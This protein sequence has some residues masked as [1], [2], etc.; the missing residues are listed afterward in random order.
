MSHVIDYTE[1]PVG[2]G[3]NSRLYPFLSSVATDEQRLMLWVYII[4]FDAI[5]CIDY[6]RK[7]LVYVYEISVNTI[8]K[9]LINRVRPIWLLFYISV[10]TIFLIDNIGLLIYLLR[11]DLKV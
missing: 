10:L 9:W 4:R 11:N 2:L 8:G 5:R 3:Y 7:C 1:S 6:V